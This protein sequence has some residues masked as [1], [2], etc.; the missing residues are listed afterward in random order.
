M[1]DISEQNESIEFEANE[2]EQ[3]PKKSK[4][5]GK[6]SDAGGTQ[7]VRQGA[8]ADRNASQR[9]KKIR[10]TLEEE[11]SGP[12]HTYM[13]KL[14]ERGV[15]NPDVSRLVA[16]AFKEQPE[17]WWD[18]QLEE[19]TPLEWRVQAALENPELRDKLVSLLQENTK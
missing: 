2:A 10:L 3:D 14:K 6:K 17:S 18:A 8:D 1:V 13:N 12:L 16:N 11:E 9:L 4:T 5:K 7:E 15:K 19:E